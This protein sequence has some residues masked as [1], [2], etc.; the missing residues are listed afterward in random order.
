MGFAA[1]LVHRVGRLD[2]ERLGRPAVAHV[3]GVREDGPISPI[4]RRTGR[5]ET[6]LESD[7]A[8]RTRLVLRPRDSVADQIL[9]DRK[10]VNVL[11]RISDMK[12]RTCD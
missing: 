6:V 10:R 12:P 2:R 3:S 4:G 1:V 8:S 7:T 5:R 9:W 11:W